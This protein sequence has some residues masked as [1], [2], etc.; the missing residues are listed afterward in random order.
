VP[1]DL[2][3][4]HSATS[5]LSLVFCRS[6]LKYL[7]TWLRYRV[8]LGFDSRQG[9]RFLS[10]HPSTLPLDLADLPVRREYRTL[11]G[12]KR[13]ERGADHSPASSER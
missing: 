5:Y 8:R 13:L 11:R 10:S 3:L 7:G 12:V 9:A 2:F 4:P 1:R 6:F